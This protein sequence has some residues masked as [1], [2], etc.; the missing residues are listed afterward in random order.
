MLEDDERRLEEREDAFADAMEAA[1]HVHFVQG[2]MSDALF[3]Y[4]SERLASELAACDYF[5]DA[6]AIAGLVGHS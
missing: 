4:E 6:D 5:G 1:C 3:A 2:G